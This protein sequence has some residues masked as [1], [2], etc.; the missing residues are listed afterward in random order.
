ML[1][2]FHQHDGSDFFAVYFGDPAALTL[3]I[4]VVDEI[5]DDLSANAFE[6]RDPAVFLRVKFGVTRH[7][8]AEIAW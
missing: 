8:P 3:W 2:I 5:R 4:A 7:D 6:R 1:R